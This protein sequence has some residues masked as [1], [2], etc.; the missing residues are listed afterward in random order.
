MIAGYVCDLKSPNTGAGRR[1][2]VSL[3]FGALVRAFGQPGPPSGDGKV[4]AEWRFTNIVSGETYTIHDYKQTSLY[5]VS[6]QTPEAFR[7]RYWFEPYEWSVG[8]LVG[9]DVEAFIAWI[10]RVCR[11]R[12]SLTS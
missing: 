1:G 9:S 7:G 4:S 2:T 12:L 8:G 6:Y 10:L 11:P 3:T 5:N